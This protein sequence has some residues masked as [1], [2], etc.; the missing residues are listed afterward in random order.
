[1]KKL[2]RKDTATPEQPVP[3]RTFVVA[4]DSHCLAFD[5]LEIE[6]RKLRARFQSAFCSSPTG[7]RASNIAT[8]DEGGS[9]VL[10]GVLTAALDQAYEKAAHQGGPDRGDIDILLSLGGVDTIVEWGSPDWH[11]YDVIVPDFPDIFDPD[12]NCLPHDLL[13][14]WLDRDF[15]HVSAAF[16]LLNDRCEGQFAVLAPPPPHADNQSLAD[17]CKARGI[18]TEYP[19][20][21]LRAKLAWMIKQKIAAAC[22][23]ARIRFI[24][25]WTFAAQDR[26]L[27]REFELDGFHANQ[28]YAERAAKLAMEPA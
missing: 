1:M 19:D 18:E 7:L 26:T 5:G 8:P 15:H 12:K 23:S 16:V 14:E 13:Q 28:H 6:D 22:T 20:V 4:G 10:D 24:D 3:Q 27:R 25:T 21:V 11:E 17:H 9:P 2:W